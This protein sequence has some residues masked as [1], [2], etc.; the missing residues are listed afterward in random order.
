MDSDE[1]VLTINPDPTKRGECIERT[2]YEAVRDAILDNLSEYGPMTL[3]QLG[4]LV[5]EQLRYEFDGSI[6]QYYTAVKMDMMVRGEICRA[7]SY[8]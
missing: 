8:F 6:R 5:E 7:P 1:F 4:C 3:T 2:A